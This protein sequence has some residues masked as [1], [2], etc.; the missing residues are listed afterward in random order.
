MKIVFFNRWH[1]GDVFSAKGYIQDLIQQLRGINPQVE[2]SHC[3]I[4]PYKTMVD[5]GINHI[6]AE[7]LP[8]GLLDQH[9]FG[10]V[11]GIFY[12]NTWIGSYG[13][14]AIPPGEQH[15]NYPSLHTMWRQ[16]YDHLNKRYSI[17]L[18]FTE[19]VGRY[20]ATSDWVQWQIANAFTWVSQN[21]NNNVLVCNGLVRSTQTNVGLMDDIV[22][23]LA[24]EYRE[25]RFICTNRFSTEGFPHTDNIYFTDDINRGCVDGDINEIAF[26]STRCDVI[27]GKNSGPFMFTHVKENLLDPNKAFVSLSHRPSDSYVFGIKGFPCRYYHSSSDDSPTVTA[28]IRR[29]IDEKGSKSPLE[30]IITDP[31]T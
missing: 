21:A 31:T 8:P 26:I 13:N 10:D 30:M 2:I 14:D 22:R 11:N 19:D 5:L 3:Q 25:H 15:A 4:N 18:E 16:I 12:I 20:I 17:Q 27:I 6:P 23:Q 29:A 28:A 1:N 9:R 7:E 24:A